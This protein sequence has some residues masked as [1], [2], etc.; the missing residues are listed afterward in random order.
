[1]ASDCSA[2]SEHAVSMIA[3]I[4]LEPRRMDPSS[5]FEFVKRGDDRG[6]RCSSAP[7]HHHFEEKR[8]RFSS[9]LCWN[10]WALFWPLLG[11]Q[12]TASHSA[13]SQAGCTKIIRRG[14]SIFLPT[15]GRPSDRSFKRSTGGARSLPRRRSRLGRAGALGDSQHE[16][17][18]E[19]ACKVASI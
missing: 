16:L 17:A 3:Q 15:K 5:L 6:R 11:T 10:N 9:N 14:S 7:N 2:T 4:P 18:H 8:C 13:S 1:M 12:H 19:R